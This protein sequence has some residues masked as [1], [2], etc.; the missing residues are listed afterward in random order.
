MEKLNS[1]KIEKKTIAYSAAQADEKLVHHLFSGV[2]GVSFIRGPFKMYFQEI[3]SPASVQTFLMNSSASI[4]DQ[5][6][7]MRKS[8]VKTNSGATTFGWRPPYTKQDLKC[9]DRDEKIYPV[10]PASLSY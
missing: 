2:S 5:I 9:C 4:C 1:D 3:S 10:L 7:L 6:G 8:K